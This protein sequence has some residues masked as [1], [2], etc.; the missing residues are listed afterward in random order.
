MVNKKLKEYIDGCKLIKYNDF[1]YIRMSD[2]ILEKYKSGIYDR[3]L[4]NFNRAILD[5]EKLGTV[6]PNNERPIFYLYMVPFDNYKELLDFPACFDLGKG[7]GKPVDSFESNGFDYALGYSE[8]LFV[9]RKQTISKYANTLHEVAHL[10]N[11]KFCNKNRFIHE[12]FADAVAFYSFDMESKFE[13]HFDMIK[14]LTEDDIYSVKDLLRAEDSDEFD[15]ISIMPAINCS[16]VKGYVSSYLFTRVILEQIELKYGVS[17]YEATNIYL[18]MLN[19]ELHSEGLV[20]YLSNKL[21][22]SFDILYEDKDYQ[23]QVINGLKKDRRIV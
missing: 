2:D 6:Y 14:N 11:S 17:R 18:N 7:G 19:N 10:V 12:G 3:E 1:F 15:S 4:D 16:F 13:Q 8:N 9:N 22:L 5:I 20:E 23:F 21:D